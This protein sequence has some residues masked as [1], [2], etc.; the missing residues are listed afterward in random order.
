MGGYAPEY[1]V[2]LHPRGSLGAY[3]PEKGLCALF[4]PVFGLPFLQFAPFLAKVHD[5]MMDFLKN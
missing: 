4:Y 1:H 2:F 5:E 3:A